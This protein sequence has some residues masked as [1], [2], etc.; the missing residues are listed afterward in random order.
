MVSEDR[1]FK[2]RSIG[3]QIAML[4]R[5]GSKSKGSIWC[6]GSDAPYATHRLY[7]KHSEVKTEEIRSTSTLSIC[8][9]H[10][11]IV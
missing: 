10:K 5:K 8:C 4:I 6:D 1:R 7:L 9:W 11:L 3:P 2:I